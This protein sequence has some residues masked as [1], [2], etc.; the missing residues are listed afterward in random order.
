MTIL[1]FSPS[2]SSRAAKT[3][4]APKPKS[5]APNKFQAAN[6]KDNQWEPFGCWDWELPG[7]FVLEIWNF[8]VEVAGESHAGSFGLLTFSFFASGEDF[9]KLQ[10]PNPKLQTSFKEK[11]D[12]PKGDRRTSLGIWELELPWDL[13]LGIWSFFVWV[14]GESRAGPPVAKRL[15]PADLV[16]SWASAAL[17]FV[18]NRGLSSG[19]SAPASSHLRH[20]VRPAALALSQLRAFLLQS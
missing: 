11:I 12:V 14:T 5:Q 18:A 17:I 16:Y 15:G 2:E 10:S 20:T 8:V 4:E 13:V 19:F 3:S 6:P 9:G 7:N 1:Y